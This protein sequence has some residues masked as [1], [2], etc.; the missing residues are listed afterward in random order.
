MKSTASPFLTDNGNYIVD[1]DVGEIFDPAGLD[2]A[3]SA[4]PGVVGTGLFVGMAD[5]V[6]FGDDYG[7]VE[8]SP[9]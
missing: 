3:L 9:T 2:C 4:M 5:L 6:I 8:R 7:T 1:V